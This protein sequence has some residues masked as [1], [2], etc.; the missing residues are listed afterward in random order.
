MSP[1]SML[2][3]AFVSLAFSRAVLAYGPPGHTLV[4]DIA[5][6][7]LDA[8][9]RTKVQALIGDLSLGFVARLADDIKDLD[10]GSKLFPN[11]EKDLEALSQTLREQLQDFHDANMGTTPENPTELLHHQFHFVDIPAKDVEKYSL[12]KRGTSQTDIVQMMKFC[13][14]VLRREVAEDNQFKITRPVALILL[15]H[16]TGDIHQPLHVGAEYF[17]RKGDKVNP[18]ASGEKRPSFP[19]AGGNFLTVTDIDGIAFSREHQTKLHGMWD[20]QAF[21][22]AK[23]QIRAETHKSKMSEAEYA[24]FYKD[25]PVPNSQMPTALQLVDWPE[26]WANEIQPIAKTAHDKLRFEN[27]RITKGKGAGAHG[28]VA[29][30]ESGQYLNWAGETVRKEIGLAGFRLADLLQKALE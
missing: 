21:D 1:K 11:S 2:F 24:K 30:L 17:T 26:A 12:G 3:A 9:T 4:G 15:V 5:D 22:E 29:E 19:D 25:N 6:N 7:V 28:S 16:Y 14:R 13:I 27:I 20:S 10:P 23:R 8:D 18:D